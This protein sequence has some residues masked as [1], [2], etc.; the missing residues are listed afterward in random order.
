MNGGA[1]AGAALEAGEAPGLAVV[2]RAPQQVY[3][4]SSGS[5]RR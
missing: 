4:R 5:P 3:R 1:I 2:L